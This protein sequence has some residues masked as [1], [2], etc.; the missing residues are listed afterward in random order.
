MN[1]KSLCNKCAACRNN[2]NENAVLSIGCLFTNLYAIKN[3][4]APAPLLSFFI[5]LGFANATISQD[6]YQKSILAC[7]KQKN[8]CFYSK[9]K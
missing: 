2:R 5:I 1:Q 7:R 4:F 3:R 8:D 9:S 6:K